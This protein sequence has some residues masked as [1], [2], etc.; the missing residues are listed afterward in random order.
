MSGTDR[1]S[2]ARYN[3]VRP[4]HS[5]LAHRFVFVGDFRDGKIEV[6]AYWLAVRNAQKRRSFSA[7]AML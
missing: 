6:G 2:A 3:M 1:Y 7:Q 4:L 5:P